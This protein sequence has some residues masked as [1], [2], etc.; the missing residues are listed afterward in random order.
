VRVDGTK[1]HRAGLLTQPGW[2]ARLSGPNQSSPVRRGVF[3]L[4]KLMCQP[5][6]PPPAGV[7]T[8]PPMPTTA[9]TTRER[10]DAHEK[11]TFCASCHDRI[12][13]AGFLLENFDGMGVWRDKE[14]GQSV[15]ASGR[16]MLTRDQ[17]LAGS[18]NGAIELSQKLAGSGQVSDCLARGWLRFALGRPLVDGDLCTLNDVQRRFA[19]GEGSFPELLVAIARSEAFR[20]YVSQP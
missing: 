10:F 8:E 13:A 6:E 14:N 7:N 4:D 20:S 1:L 16:L 11:D 9:K 17:A 15:D 2:L 18:F 3:V 5:P 12:D 19:A